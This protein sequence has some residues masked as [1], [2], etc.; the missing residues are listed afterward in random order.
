MTIDNGNP[1]LGLDSGTRAR[2]PPGPLNKLLGV[3]IGGVT[4]VVSLLFS[5]VVFAVVLA[6]GVLV[7]A[8]F[9]WR[10]RKLRGRIRAQMETQ[11]QAQHDAPSGA[12]HVWPPHG[13]NGALPAGFVIEG[14]YIR[15]APRDDSD[16][17]RNADE[18]PRR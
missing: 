10:T 9:W 4:V 17:P 15:E 11:M 12:R 13:D 6:V 8:Y 16:V 7:G 18:T 1:R 14:D 3:V 5:F 2:P